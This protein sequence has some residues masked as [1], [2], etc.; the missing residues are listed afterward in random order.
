MIADAQDVDD[1]GFGVGFTQLNTC[2]K[3]AVDPFPEVGD[4]KKWVGQ[5][6]READARNSGRIGSYVQSRLSD[7]ARAALL[8]TM[9][10]A[11]A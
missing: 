2:K 11:A 1:S 9:A 4:V 6:L 10:A 3:T 5:Y 8:E 7:Q